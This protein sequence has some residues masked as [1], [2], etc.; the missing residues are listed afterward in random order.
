MGNAVK[1][2][3]SEPIKHDLIA[4]F[5][6]DFAVLLDKARVASAMTSTECWQRLYADTMANA[7]KI[8]R[9]MAEQLRGLSAT[10]E[11]RGLDENGE[12]ELGELKKNSMALN[13]DVAAFNLFTIEPIRASSREYDT[14]VNR[15]RGE[16]KREEDI[17][18]LMH[19]NL[20]LSM[21]DAIAKAERIAWDDEEGRIV[22]VAPDKV[23]G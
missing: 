13:S 5:E 22:I 15:Y 17:N 8:R 10:M 18:P 2:P 21:R 9:G 6:D 7:R 20:E 23:D 19:Q 12:K 11:D 1:V 14:L 3:A 4:R 16:A